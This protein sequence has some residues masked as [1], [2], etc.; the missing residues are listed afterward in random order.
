MTSTT[1]I[2]LDNFREMIPKLYLQKKFVSNGTAS[3]GTPKPD[4]MLMQILDKD[5]RLKNASMLLLNVRSKYGISCGLA[6]KK[7]ENSEG[8]NGNGAKKDGSNLQG[9]SGNISNVFSIQAHLNDNSDEFKEMFDSL[10]T[11]LIELLQK[12]S[13][14][15]FKKQLSNE[16][17][18]DRTYPNCRFPMEEKSAIRYGAHVSFEMYK[19][20]KKLTKEWKACNFSD[21]FDFS[22]SKGY[23]GSYSLTADLKVWFQQGTGKLGLKFPIKQLNFDPVTESDDT[24]YQFALQKG[25]INLDQSDNTGN[26]QKRRAELDL[27]ETNNKNQRCKSD[28]DEALVNKTQSDLTHNSSSGNSLS[29]PGVEHDILTS[30]CSNESDKTDH[31]AKHLKL[32]EQDYIPTTVDEMVQ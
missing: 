15:L 10:S 28:T 6:K 12:D 5:G 23:D 21:L 1:T 4:S 16:V 32:N 30:V 18:L 22:K 14:E 11:R 24:L 9:S 25:L 31:V 8:G 3:D 29:G 26:G 17:L 27:D 20:T 2:T 19:E 13:V 7:E